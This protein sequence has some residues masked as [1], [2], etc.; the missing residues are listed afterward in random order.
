MSRIFI[1]GGAGFIGSFVARR[2]L[3][4]GHEVALYDSF[5]SYTYPLDEVYIYHVTKRVE[6][7]KGEAHVIRGSTTDHDFLRH[8]L[9][10]FDPERIIHLAAMP[11]ANLAIER[12]Q[13]AARTIVTGTM[14]LLEVA[15][16]LSTLERVVYISSSMVYGDFIEVP[17]GEDHHKDPKEMYGSLKLAGELLTRAFGRLYGVDYAIVRPSAVYGM[18]DNN[19]RVM[20]IFIENALAGK[21]LVVRGADQ[22]LDFSFVTDTADGIIAA[23]LHPNA[24]GREFNITRGHGRTILEMA[25]IIA[26][27]IPGTEIRVEDPDVKMPARGTLDITRAHS[28]IG[29]EPQVDIEKGILTYLDFIKQRKAE[30]GK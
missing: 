3:D 6:W 22:S 8:T 15:R 14:N 12:P 18:T 4:M 28:L 13:E 1:T 26:E 21:A 5:V 23:T 25:E 20:S 7:L 2:L 19:R 17:A 27:H 10:D 29:Y 30:I 16:D 9:T 24:S 11:L